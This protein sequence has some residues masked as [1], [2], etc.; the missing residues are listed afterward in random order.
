[1]RPKVTALPT[2]KAMRVMLSGYYG[3]DNFGDDLI[4][5]ALSGAL[6]AEGCRPVVLSAMPSQ[7]FTR[8]KVKAVDRM[9]PLAVLWHMMQCDLFLSGGGG[10]FQ[11]SSGPA[12]PIYYGLL[13][14][15]AKWLGLPTVHLFQSIGPL[16]TRSGRW[17]TKQALKHCSWLAVRDEPSADWVERLIGK[18]P[19]VTADAVWLL[20]SEA[21]AKAAQL[22]V[23][24]DEWVLGLSLRPHPRLNKAGLERLAVCLASL[25]QKS[26]KPVR[27]VLLVAQAGMDE[28]PLLE[29][30]AAFKQAWSLQGQVKKHQYPVYKPEVSFTWVQNP[31]ELEQ[32]IALCHTLIG[33]RFHSLVAG[34]LYEVPV[35]GLVYDPKVQALL[36][37]VP[38]QGFNVEQLAELSP[39]DLETYFSTY[40]Q[41]LQSWVEVQQAKSMAAWQT[42]TTNLLTPPPLR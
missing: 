35:L 12:S 5:Q 21:R 9:N 32:A 36:D 17:W 6:K 19:M 18:R 30:Q 40:P 11:D 33:M 20:A 34:L 2:A 38:L 1:M 39:Q 14:I 10:L 28:G 16:N 26:E 25:V 41:N 24:T 42:F 27:F 31:Q 15:V 23:A 7:T 22:S 8:F 13:L 37:S 29:W 3:F 4:L